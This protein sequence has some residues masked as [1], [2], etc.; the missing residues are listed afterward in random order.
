M[1]STHSLT[2]KSDNYWDGEIVG[3]AEYNITKPPMLW[4]N[5]ASTSLGALQCQLISLYNKKVVVK[6]VYSTRAANCTADNISKI[7]Q[8]DTCQS[9]KLL[10]VYVELAFAKTNENISCKHNT[11]IERTT[12]RPSKSNKNRNPTNSINL[13]I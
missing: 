6:P 1:S 13:S 10:I 9:L 4:S 12:L 3:K 8:K 11:D 2:L 5:S 7:L